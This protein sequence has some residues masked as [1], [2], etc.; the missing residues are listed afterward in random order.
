MKLLKFVLIVIVAYFTVSCANRAAGPTGGPKD[1]IPPVVVKSMPLNGSINFKKKEIQVYFDENVTLDKPADNIVVSPPQK[2]QPITKANAKLLTVSFQEDLKDSTTYSIHFGNAIVDLNEKNPLKNYVFSFA[3]GNEIDSLQVSG[4]LFDAQNLNPVSNII[5]GLHKNLNDSA[6]LTDQFVRIA[7]TSDEGD[8]VIKNIKSGSYKLYALSDLNRDFIYQPGEKVAFFDSIVV[9]EVSSVH[10]V[11]TVW[12]DSVTIDTVVFKTIPYYSP[13]DIKMRLFQ[14]TKKRQYLVKSERRD[15]RFFSLFFNDKQDSL[16]VITPLNFDPSTKFLVQKS[17]KQDS[18][19]YWIQDPTVYQ[20]DTLVMEIKYEKSDSLFVLVPAV[21]TLKLALRKQV[22]PAKS[23]SKTDKPI[24]KPLSIKTNLAGSLDVYNPILLESEE[25]IALVDTSKIALMLKVDSVYK[26]IKYNLALH[27]SIN[28]T[29]RISHK[30]EPQKEY[31]LRLDSAALISVYG[32][33]AM[34]L[35]TSFKIKSLDEYS[36]FKIVLENFDSL[37]IIQ[38]V[39]AKEAV[40]QSLRAKKEGT[41]FEYIKPGDYFVR[42]FIDT[43]NNGEWDTGNLEKRIQPEQVIYFS[44]KLVLKANW[45]M[46][47]TWNHLDQENLFKKPD[48]LM[49]KTKKS[50]N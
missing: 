28:R 30:W 14:D 7:K 44:K 47:E 11:D 10:Q 36:T 17:V 27:D 6:I 35:K 5:V 37:A 18:L 48:D 40:I 42:L 1:S 46:E 20:Q 31:E 22:V 39:D 16:P 12:K 19:M 15:E 32:K 43:N 13:N 50:P 41:K 34:P 21:D 24:I 23:K 8:F 45:E 49:P 2:V 9:P 26:P 33:T 38:V 4:R 29:F 25:P 3:T